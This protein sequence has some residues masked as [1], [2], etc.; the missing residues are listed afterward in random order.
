[1]ESD[2]GYQ[3]DV[4]TPKTY[5]FGAVMVILGILGA[6]LMISRPGINPLL[7][8]FFYSIPSN[9]AI[10]LFPHEPVL[11]WYGKTVNLWQLSI[12]ATFG[13]I[14]AAYLDYKFFAPVLNL[15]YSIRY[16]SNSFYKKACRWFNK[17][18]FTT[19]VVAGFTPIPFFPFKFLVYSSKYPLKKYLLAV[20]AGRFPRYFLLAYAGYLFQIP[21]WIIFGSFFAMIAIVYHR[22][23][24]EWSAKPFLMLY[25]SMKRLN[26]KT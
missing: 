6:Y 16:K 26:G 3:F 2:S 8:I 4:M 13:T 15:S 25:G 1:M 19:I 14:L 9:A 5:I 22:K 12:A 11:V 24:F 23:I 18:P 17:I 21:D 10:A 7:I 20:A